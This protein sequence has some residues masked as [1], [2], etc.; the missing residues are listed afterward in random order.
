M[1]KTVRPADADEMAILAQ[2][3][4]SLGTAALHT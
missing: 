4:K 3:P 2:H 1:H